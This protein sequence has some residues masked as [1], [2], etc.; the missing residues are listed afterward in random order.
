VEL[1]VTG[2]NIKPSVAEQMKPS[3]TKRPELAFWCSLLST[4]IRLD[5]RRISE[6]LRTRIFIFHAQRRNISDYEHIV[7]NSKK[8]P[9]VFFFSTRAW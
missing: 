9:L 6:Q 5:I 8:Y 7:M 2:R 1:S 3:E 4:V